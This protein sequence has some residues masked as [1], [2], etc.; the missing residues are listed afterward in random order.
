M[1][2]RECVENF[3]LIA[4]LQAEMYTSTLFS[5]YFFSSLYIVSFGE[6]MQQSTKAAHNEHY[7]NIF[8]EY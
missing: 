4:I 1:Y 5:L 3:M 7:L 8:V 2:W 6:K